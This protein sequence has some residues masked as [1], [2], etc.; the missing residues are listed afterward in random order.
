MAEVVDPICLNVKM[1]E[2]CGC[3]RGC[4][5]EMFDMPNCICDCFEDELVIDGE[6]KRLYCTLGQFSLIRMERDSQLL[7]D[8]V[9]FCMPEKECAGGSEETPCDLFKRIRF[10]VDEFFPPDKAHGDFGPCKGDCK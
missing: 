4:N 10:P 5:D 9:E 8:S 1:I 3:D 7:I 2:K 6:D